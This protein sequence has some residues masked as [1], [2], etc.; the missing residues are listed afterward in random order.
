MT[1]TLRILTGRWAGQER[2][3]V[4]V[5]ASGVTALKLLSD[6]GS[7][8]EWWEILWP[9][10]PS[11]DP[12]VREW[13]SADLVSRVIRAAFHGRPVRVLGKI[14]RFPADV[15]SPAFAD[16]LGRLEDTIADSS[17]FVGVVSDDVDS[18]LVIGAPSLLA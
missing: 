15:R 17:R 14:W 3:A 1:V 7:R 12:V 5:M 16:M 13:V 9:E 10:L 11:T 8:D 6:L 4:D 18:G 2:A